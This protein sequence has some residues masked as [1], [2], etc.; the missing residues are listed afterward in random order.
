MS[1]GSS[2]SRSISA[3]WPQQ[4]TRPPPLLLSIDGTDRRTDGGTDTSPFYDAYRICVTM[5]VITTRSFLNTLRRYVQVCSFRRNNNCIGLHA[6]CQH[7]LTATARHCYLSSRV[8]DDS[9]PGQKWKDCASIQNNLNRS[10]MSTPVYLAMSY[11]PIDAVY[12]CVQSE[13]RSGQK[14]SKRKYKLLQWEAASPRVAPCEQRW[15]HRLQ[16]T[17]QGMPTAQSRRGCG[18]PSNAWFSGSHD[19]TVQTASWSAQPFSQGS[20]MCSTDRQTDRQTT[21]HL[22][23]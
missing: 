9:N 16:R 8:V 15:V 1:R 19:S 5:T 6:N 14:C 17:S 11:R 23:Q 13:T 10:E 21:L 12:A 2:S 3:W 4:Q 18:P 7:S 20:T 22:Q